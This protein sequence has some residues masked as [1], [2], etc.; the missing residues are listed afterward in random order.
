MFRTRSAPNRSRQPPGGLEHPARCDVLAEQHHPVVAG[1]LLGQRGGD[2]LPVGQ[3]RHCQLPSLHTS[4]QAP[5]GS[6]AGRA[7]ICWASSARLGLDP[8]VDLVQLLRGRARGGQHGPGAQQRVPLAPPRDFLGRPVRGAVRGRVSLEPV[9]LRL[10]QARAL[11]VPGRA[12][13]VADHLPDGGDVVAVHHDPVQPVGGG[14]VGGGQRD[15]DHLPDRGV[16]HVPVVLAHEHD[17][18]PPHRGQVDR[19]VERADV[20]RAVA[21]EAHRDL[22]RCRGSGPPRPVRRRS[23][24]ARRRSRRSRSS[25]AARW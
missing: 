3:F 21:E 2:G 23:A 16:L 7:R 19:L 10:D 4:V 6:G 15:R 14:P 12:D 25:R 22:V 17:R 9:G 20:G 18:Q 11:P 8:R 24:G 1:H 13:R 5:A